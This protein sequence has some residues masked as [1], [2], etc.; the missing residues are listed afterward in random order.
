MLSPF[1]LIAAVTGSEGTLSPVSDIRPVILSGGSGTRLWPLSTARLPKQFADLIP[2]QDPLFTATLGRLAGLEGLGP[3]VVVTGAAHAELVRDAVAGSDALVLVEPAG[4]NTAP[5][6]VAAALAVSPD[7]VLCV[8][9]SDHL[10]GDLDAFRA[11]VGAAAA[12]ARDGRIVTFGVLPRRPDTGYG[13]LELGEE[14][15]G[16]AH[17]IARF[18]EKPDAAEAA[19]LVDDGRHLWNAGMFVLTAAAAIAETARWRPEVL[20]AV[21]SAVP[22]HPRGF[23]DLGES[24]L[25]AEAISFDHAV[26]EQTDLGV[27]LPLDAGWD[28]VGSYQSIHEHLPQD[29]DGNAVAGRVVLDGVRDS[30][31]I[32]RS[33]VVAVAGLSEV[34]VIE[35]PDAV[36][37]V[38]LDESQRVRDV[39]KGAETA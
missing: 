8:L 26:M 27:V 20:A 31:V 15:A 35:T 21:R 19:R 10:I 13:Y 23:V 1:T 9:P 28:D 38:A 6:V 16:G 33:R 18:K 5:A 17:L 34:A 3:P 29:A 25:G 7:D 22:P 30:L 32:A 2:G 14:V 12:L 39:A 36:L 37:V 4:R 24:F 11:A